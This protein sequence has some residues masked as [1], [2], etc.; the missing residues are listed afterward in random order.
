ME[1]KKT[2][3]IKFNSNSKISGTNS[4]SNYYIDWSA[5]LDNNKPYNLTWTY[6]AQQNVFGAATKVASIYINI[7]ANNYIANS[8]GAGITQNIGNLKADNNVFY[9]DTNVNIP[10]FLNSRPL[11]NKCEYS[12]II[13][14]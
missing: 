3:T 1:Y 7:F 6:T 8:Y 13:L 2:I 10:I 4:N 5:I 11:E 12:N 14:H 9:A